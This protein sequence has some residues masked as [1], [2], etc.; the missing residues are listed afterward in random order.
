VDYFSIIDWVEDQKL[1][2]TFAIK[3]PDFV[4]IDRGETALALKYNSKTMKTPVV[5]IKGKNLLVQK[6]K[7]LAGINNIPIVENGKL[8]R[9]IYMK[10][11]QGD[12]IPYDCY[13]E[14]AEIYCATKVENKNENETKDKDNYENIINIKRKKYD[15]V[16]SI[17]V[18]EKIV[19]ELGCNLHSLIKKEE[20]RI[21]LLGFDVFKP[22]I[23]LNMKLR[24]D[25]YCVKING[26]D[27]K[28][29]YII[30]SFQVMGCNINIDPNLQ[31]RNG[32][33]MVLQKHAN[34]LIGR[35]D[36]LLFITQIREKQPV[37]INEILKYY[38][39]GEIKKVLQG[40]LHEYVSSQNIVTILETMADV[41]ENDRHNIELIQKKVRESIGRDICYPYIK[42][43]SI[44]VVVF[45]LESEK[46]ISNNIINTSRGRIL[47]Q[48]IREKVVKLLSEA[49]VIFK[50]NNI[51]P[52]LLCI[53]DN[54]KKIRN[55]IEKIFPELVVLS[56]NEIPVDIPVKIIKEIKLI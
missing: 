7:K 51:N 36:V 13:K 10:T 5:L 8:T 42:D 31:L 55:S 26:Q 22:K 40:L 56:Y 14:V 52:I 9:L 11:K 32:I 23:N 38:S 20:L 3:K 2:Y 37:L 54:R 30:I 28:R 4:L 29:G 18:P 49:I 43:N 45:D 41:G 53:P 12:I 46:N 24:E 47:N 15:E 33:S 35:D 50:N 27:V 48:S 19:I 25:E 17:T 44:N 16:L 39:M 21:S 1:K 34:E 6:L